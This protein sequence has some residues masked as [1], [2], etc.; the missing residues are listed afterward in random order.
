M[1]SPDRFEEA[2]IEAHV[3]INVHDAATG[4]ATQTETTANVGSNQLG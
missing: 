1:R 2:D 3:Y 4:E